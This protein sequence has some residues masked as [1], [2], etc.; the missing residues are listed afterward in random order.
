MEKNKA[1]LKELEIV[2][3]QKVFEVVEVSKRSS[4]EQLLEQM[5]SKVQEPQ[6]PAITVKR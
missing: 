6:Q 1:E 2:H 5:G 3:A 4:V